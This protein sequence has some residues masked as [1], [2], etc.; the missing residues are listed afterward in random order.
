MYVLKR[1][2]LRRCAE[3][4]AQA[5]AAVL[6]RWLRC[7]SD[8]WLRCAVGEQ[9]DAG[10]VVQSDQFNQ[11]HDLRL[12]ALEQQ[13]AL[14]APQ[15]IREHRQVEH[16]RGVGKHEV[17]EVNEDVTLGSKCE[18]KCPSPEA[19]GASILVTCAEQHRRVVGEL[20]D[21]GTLLSRPAAMQP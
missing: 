21:R 16:Q 13:P 4:G 3:C 19:L 14:A 12:R 20:D 8:R 9:L 15:A 7:S 1:S 5:L 11:M 10:Q 18:D 2:E 6:R 17:P